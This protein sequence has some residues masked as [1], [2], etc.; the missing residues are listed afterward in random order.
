MYLNKM[1]YIAQVFLLYFKYYIICY[2]IFLNKA[3]I[4]SIE[5]LTLFV[6]VLASY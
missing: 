1:I 4:L 5:L 2:R 6:Y 3:F